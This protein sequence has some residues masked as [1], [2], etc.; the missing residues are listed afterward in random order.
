MGK[1]QQRKGAD[2]ERELADLLRAKGY[3][4][5]RGGSMTYGTIPDIVGLPDIHV[6]VKRQERLDLIDAIYQAETD[7][8]KFHDGQP[9]VFPR[10]PCMMLR[11][12]SEVLSQ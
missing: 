6:E 3:D 5:K 10:K 1:K 11:E 4:V 2:G 9:A 8:K 7:S 12:V